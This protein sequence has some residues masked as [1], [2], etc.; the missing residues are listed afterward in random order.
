MP[1]RRRPRP[2]WG[3]VHRHVPTSHLRAG[4]PRL[5]AAVRPAPQPQRPEGP[6]RRRRSRPVGRRR[7][8]GLPR[9]VRRPHGLRRLRPPA[10]RP[11]LAAR[12]RGR[13]DRVRG[14][15]PGQRAVPELGGDRDRHPGGAGHRHRCHR[16]VHRLR[17]RLRWPRCPGRRHRDRGAD[18]PQPPGRPGHRDRPRRRPGRAAARP[19]RA[20]CLRADPGHGLRRGAGSATDD[21]AAD[22]TGAADNVVRRRQARTPC[23]SRRRPRHRGSGRSSAGSRSAWP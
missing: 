9:P 8:A 16:V 21:N 5:P 10:L 11:G 22:D 2:G 4:A 18:Q 15:A 14:A 3:H 12:P 7:P 1:S 23:T 19:G 6:R 20:R 17:A 13:R